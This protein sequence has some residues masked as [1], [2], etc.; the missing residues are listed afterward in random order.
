MSLTKH[1]LAYIGDD[2]IYTL[3]LDFVKICC[4]HDSKF[5]DVSYSCN[6]VY[7][8]RPNTFKE[9][10]RNSNYYYFKILN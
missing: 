5:V 1:G 3:I 8:F 4:L 9:E 10:K 2:V 6:N 7:F